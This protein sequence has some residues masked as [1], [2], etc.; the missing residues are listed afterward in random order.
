MKNTIDKTM[1]CKACRSA[2]PDILFGDAGQ[3]PD[4]RRHV[5]GCAACRQE[6][7]ELQATFALLDEWKAP[8]PSAFFDTRLKAR[9]REAAEEAPAG[10]WERLGAWWKFTFNHGTLRPAM[11]GAL[12]LVLLAGGGTLV[13][14]R[15]DLHSGGQPAVTNPS[16]ATVNDLRIL[17]NNQ[18][19][20]QQMDQLL[21]DNSDD[22]G[23]S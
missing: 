16:S 13:S 17:D 12:A 1:D 19:A 21:D 10:Y 11:A 15:S 4:V 20:L 22:G 5:A 6:L 8:E 23:Q 9:L 18:E 3:S 2:L 7:E 14:F